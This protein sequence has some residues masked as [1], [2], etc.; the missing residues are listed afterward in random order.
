MINSTS[1]PILRY[2]PSTFVN[3]LA[4]TN[5]TATT[6]TEFTSNTN[7]TIAAVIAA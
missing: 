1:K 7:K 4:I 2:S 6:G 3:V 5:N